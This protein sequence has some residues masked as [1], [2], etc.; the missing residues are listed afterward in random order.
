MKV[1]RWEVH[2]QALLN[3]YSALGMVWGETDCA[4][5]CADA[6]RAQLGYDPAAQYRGTYSTPVGAAKIIKG[7]GCDCVSEVPAIWLREIAPGAAKVGDVLAFDGTHGVHLAVC[8]GE[9]GVALRGEGRK[10]FTFKPSRDAL[11]AYEVA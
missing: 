6:V 4:M 9:Y 7:L 1:A 8:M 5:L 2:L 11:K 10:G 3:R